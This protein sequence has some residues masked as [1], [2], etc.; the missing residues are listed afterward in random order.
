MKDKSVVSREVVSVIENLAFAF[1]DA[2]PRITPLAFV[3]T[4]H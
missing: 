4:D 2:W 3:F 1:T